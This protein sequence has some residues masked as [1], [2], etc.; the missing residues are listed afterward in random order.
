MI[1]KHFILSMGL[2][3]AIGVGSTISSANAQFYPPQDRAAPLP[4]DPLDRLQRGEDEIHNRIVQRNQAIQQR[5]DER[6]A[7]IDEQR[8]RFD[9]MKNYG[10][11]QRDEWRRRAEERRRD[12]REQGERQRERWRDMRDNTRRDMHD[13]THPYRSPDQYRHHH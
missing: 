1:S 8:R 5:I 10:K 6:N 9:D 3:A 7:Q 2:L 13:F 11:D 12:F 4:P